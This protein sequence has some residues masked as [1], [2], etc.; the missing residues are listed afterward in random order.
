MDIGQEVPSTAL[1]PAHFI[2]VTMLISTKDEVVVDTQP[3]QTAYP[4]RLLPE[5]QPFHDMKLRSVQRVDCP[6][7]H[8]GS[9]AEMACEPSGARVT[10]WRGGGGNHATSTA[11][12]SPGA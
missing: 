1:N 6:G 8:V 2:P 12:K 10:P 7:L 4:V 11:I 9:L 3:E 5:T